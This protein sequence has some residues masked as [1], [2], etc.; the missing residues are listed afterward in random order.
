M[1]IRNLFK[2]ILKP[3]LKLI[4][5]WKSNLESLLKHKKDAILLHGALKKK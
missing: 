4:W 3:N 1:G 5:G 2:G